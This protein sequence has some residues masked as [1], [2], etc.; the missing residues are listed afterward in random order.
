[1]RTLL[2]LSI[3]ALKA[4]MAHPQAAGQT[5]EREQF[6]RELHTNTDL[7]K[8]VMYADE[9]KN[10]LMVTVVANRKDFKNQWYRDSVSIKKAYELLDSAAQNKHDGII[11]VVRL[12]GHQRKKQAGAFGISNTDSTTARSRQ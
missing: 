5:R 6:M 4:A 12:A 9:L 11:V 1:M 3:L 7:N 2:L 10:P 8:P